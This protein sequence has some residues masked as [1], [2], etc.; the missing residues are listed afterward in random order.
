[1]RDG[2]LRPTP[3]HIRAAIKARANPPLPLAL[4]NNLHPPHSPKIPRSTTIPSSS[5]P[6]SDPRTA[7]ANPSRMPLRHAQQ[8]TFPGARG[9]H[10]HS[11]RRH[12]QRRHSR[13]ATSAAGLARLSPAHPQ[14]RH[15]RQPRYM[16]RLA[17]SITPTRI[18]QGS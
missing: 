10:P 3:F 14:D 7:K 4:P 5:L 11:R 9:R 13:R 8:H 17:S 16:A 6:V 15:R 18:R 12:D 2:S 1:M